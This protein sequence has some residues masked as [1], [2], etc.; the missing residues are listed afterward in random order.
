MGLNNSHKQFILPSGHSEE[1]TSCTFAK[2][3][4]GIIL[5]CKG[6]MGKSRVSAKGGLD[7]I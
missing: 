7:W 6:R 2:W 4:L 1:V 3:S 5:W